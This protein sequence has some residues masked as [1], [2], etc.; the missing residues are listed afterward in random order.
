MT[1]ICPRCKS[2]YNNNFTLCT[3]CGMPLKKESNGGMVTLTAFIVIAS[4][5]GMVVGFILLK[6][7]WELGV[8]VGQIH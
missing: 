7:L 3:R 8:Q 5:F 1:K 4:I 2:E 6:G